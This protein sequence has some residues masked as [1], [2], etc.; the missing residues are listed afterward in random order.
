[1]HKLSVEPW[2]VV[3][4]NRCSSAAASSSSFLLCFMSSQ[5]PFEYLVALLPLLFSPFMSMWEKRFQNPMNI[6][7]NKGETGIYSEMPINFHTYTLFYFIKYTFMWMKW[8]KISTHTHPCT[9]FKWIEYSSW[10]RPQQFGMM[11]TATAQIQQKQ[12]LY[13]FELFG[14]VM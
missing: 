5:K 2:T 7:M 10:Y 4:N 12:K 3:D 8:R 6:W 11:A 13:V 1:M 14:A 9:H